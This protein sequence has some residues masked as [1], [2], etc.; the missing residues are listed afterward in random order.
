LYKMPRDTHL[1]C[2]DLFL[3]D[4]IFSIACMRSTDDK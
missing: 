2:D 4:F 3:A 1:P